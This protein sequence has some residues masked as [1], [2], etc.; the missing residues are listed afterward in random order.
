MR[1]MVITQAVDRK[2]PVL[3]FFHRWIEEM[4]RDFES[5]LVVCLKRGDYDLPKNVDVLSLGKEEGGSRS[6]A[7]LR[8]I[9]RFYRY[10]FFQDYDAV[11]V[12]MNPE[13]VIWGGL[14]WK[15]FRKKL[16]LW[17]AHKSVT[18]KLRVAAILADGLFT[19]SKESLRVNSRKTMIMG[20]G[21]DTKRFS[22]APATT[23]REGAFSAITIGRL[24]P[25]KGYETM[26]EAMTRMKADVRLRIVG[27]AAA[28][29]D[30]VYMARLQEM[31]SFLRLQAAVSFEKPV[32]HD[33]VPAVLRSADIFI[34]AS[35]TG[36]LD[37][38]VLEAMACG[39]PALT[40]NEAFADMLALFG[41]TF[42]SGDSQAL[43]LA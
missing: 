9:G 16:G 32:V 37:K 40:S 35:K 21:I 38:A 39:V 2:D 18:W 29:G 14:Y 4:A 41:L 20:H 33:D 5:V 24:S 7:R 19:P 12:H 34:N 43:A 1:I 36:S 6:L 8:Y 30:D 10:I 28:L 26:L 27:G 25:S 13:Y 11:F 22:P 15:I 31:T 3:G 23:R 42:P 17:Y